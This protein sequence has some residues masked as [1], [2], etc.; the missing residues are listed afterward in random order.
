MEDQTVTMIQED[1]QKAY[2]SAASL[3]ITEK[4]NPG[5]VINALVQQGVNNE[6]ASRI[7]EILQGEAEKLGRRKKQKAKND[8]TY[9]AI[10]CIG[11]ILFTAITY[12]AA[13]SGGGVY[14]I[15]WGA[16]LFGAIQFFRGLI[17][18]SN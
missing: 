17:N 5:E 10:W 6:E 3:L 2:S 16:I 14:F 4:K 7:V 18:S 12:S 15:A 1:I 8:M 11:G 13:S 9:G